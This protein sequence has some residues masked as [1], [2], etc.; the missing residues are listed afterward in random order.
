MSERIRLFANGS[1]IGRPR[2]D[3]GARFWAKVDQ[4]GECWI[5]T[6][7]TFKDGYGQFFDFVGG[8][9]RNL[10]AHIVSYTMAY[11]P[12]SKGLKVCHTCDNPSCV[13]PDHLFLGTTK[14]NQEDMARK[15]RSASG[16]R[17]GRAKLTISDVAAIRRA[18]ANGTTNKSALARAFSVSDSQIHNIVRGRQWQ[19]V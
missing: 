8:R 1:R 11:G 19:T 5:W 17:N 4:S 7:S 10:R 15:G 9:K 18:Y 3:A 12:V 2:T 6:A 14:Q 16:Q 13:R